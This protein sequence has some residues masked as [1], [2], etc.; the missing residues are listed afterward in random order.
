MAALEKADG[1]AAALL[2]TQRLPALGRDEIHVWRV[3]LHRSEKP[4]EGL[5]AVLSG[6][7]GQR[8]ARYRF[9]RDRDRFVA[10]RGL[11]RV[12][13]GMYLNVEPRQLRFAYNPYGKP[14]LVPQ[15]DG[16]DVEFNLSHSGDLALYAIARGR[17]VGIDVERIDPAKGTMEIADRFFSAAEIKSLREL[18]QELRTAGF[19]NCWTRKEAY[20]KARGLGL[21]IPLDQFDVSLK[22]GEAARLIDA[23]CEPGGASRWRLVELDAGAGYAAAVAAEGQDWRLRC[24]DWGEVASL[25]FKTFKP[26]NRFAPFKTS[27]AML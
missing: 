11:L 21:A 13:L 8:A 10:A 15:P 24:F 19:F 27:S 3:S 17:A 20:I 14:A 22:P 2:E 7:E 16:T 4:L 25:P 5:A 12:L 23:R 9:A 6:D 26:F 1:R 18:P